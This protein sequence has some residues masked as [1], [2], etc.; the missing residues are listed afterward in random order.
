MSAAYRVEPW[1]QKYAVYRAGVRV[2][3]GF[4]SRLLAEARMDVMA[5]AA[6][7]APRDCI[8]CGASFMSEGPHHRMCTACR[9]CH[10]ESGD[11]AS[12]A[13]RRARMR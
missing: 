8:T 5:R 7:K 9:R 1:G 3:G 4:S 11:L 12:H 6:G 2:S 10:D 13:P